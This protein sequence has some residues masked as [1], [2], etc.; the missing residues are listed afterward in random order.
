MLYLI[1]KTLV[2]FGSSE[3]DDAAT[4]YFNL[5]D[6]D[7]DGHITKDELRAVVACL[8]HESGR[9]LLA[10]GDEVLP[11]PHVEE[12]FDV[13]DSNPKDGRIDLEEFQNFYENVI[14]PSSVRSVMDSFRV[15]SEAPSDS[16]HLSG[17]VGPSGH[18]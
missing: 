11:V 8:L 5:F 15:A 10:V 9:P 18:T 6:L 1:I 12:L 14:L 13:I 4:L 7:E 16:S 2:S 17:T 3:R